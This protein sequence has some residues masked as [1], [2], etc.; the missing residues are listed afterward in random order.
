MDCHDGHLRCVFV[1]VEAVRD[2]LRLARVNEIHEP[3]NSRL[4]LVDRTLS[5]LGV[6]DVHDRL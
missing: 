5:D 3:L 1:D 2:Q 6:V 4:E